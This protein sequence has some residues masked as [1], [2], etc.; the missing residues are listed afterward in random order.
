MNEAERSKLVNETVEACAQ[1]AERYIHVVASVQPQPTL[2]NGGAVEL[3]RL[4]EARNIAADL[5][6]LKVAI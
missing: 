2:A 3:G 6:R 4:A 1:I 5:R